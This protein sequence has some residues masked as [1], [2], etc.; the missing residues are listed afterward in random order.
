G[1]EKDFL[2]QGVDENRT[3]EE[4]L[5]LQWKVVSLLPKNEL[6][7]VKDKFIDQYYKER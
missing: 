6:T 1:F 5:G 4:T 3:I 7:K 2:T